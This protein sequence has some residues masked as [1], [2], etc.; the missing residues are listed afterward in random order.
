MLLN[1]ND[2][3]ERDCWSFVF[4]MKS[5][6]SF[7]V[8]ELQDLHLA[9]EKNISVKVSLEQSISTTLVFTCTVWVSM[10]TQ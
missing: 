9:V 3:Q 1:A 5:F 4:I 7:T 10:T 8:S 2:K 6:Y